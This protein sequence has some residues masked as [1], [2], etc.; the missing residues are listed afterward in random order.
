MSRRPASSERVLTLDRRI[1]ARSVAR[2]IGR[3]KYV[4]AKEVLV[5]QESGGS[6]TPGAMPHTLPHARNPSSTAVALFDGPAAMTMAAS[7]R[8]HVGVACYRI[9]TDS[10][11]LPGRQCPPMPG[12][13]K[14][15]ATQ[16]PRGALR[17][18]LRR[19]VLDESGHL[20]WFG[21]RDRPDQPLQ[22]LSARAS[23]DLRMLSQE[24]RVPRG[25]LLESGGF[26]NPGCR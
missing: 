15:P 26:S 19:N 25:L 24:P 17:L 22:H 10:V 12:E 2:E 13:S 3:T 6:A 4:C 9:A 7:G 14:G 20:R 16:R 21:F 23:N 18:P 11:P 5:E 1:Y 8:L